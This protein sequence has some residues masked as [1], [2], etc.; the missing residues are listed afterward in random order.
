MFIVKL[1]KQ[2][3][4]IAMHN[5]RVGSHLVPKLKPP[6]HC[7]SHSPPCRASPSGRTTRTLSSS[8]LS[9]WNAALHESKAYDA[10]LHTLNPYSFC[11]AALD[12]AHE[13]LT[14]ALHTVVA[15][16]VQ[17]PELAGSIPLAGVQA[18]GA[19]PVVA[20]EGV[21]TQVRR[22]SLLDLDGHAR[23]VV[24]HKPGLY[25]QHLRAKDRQGCYMVRI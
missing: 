1:R 22:A 19:A 13:L 11:S 6:L 2:G 15:P 3:N 8:V 18:A 24:Y 16:G 17:G 10:A 21:C 9:Q 5:P 12:A 14:P 25:G 7:H 4:G 23:L 20:V